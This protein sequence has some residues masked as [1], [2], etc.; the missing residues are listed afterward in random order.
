MPEKQPISLQ[1]SLTPWDLPHACLV[2]PH[3]L[4]FWSEHCTETLLFWDMEPG[5]RLA[6][7]HDHWQAC[8]EFLP[9]FQAAI[10]RDWPD[11]RQ[12]SQDYHGPQGQLELKTLSQTFF[13]SQGEIFT[14][15]IPIKDFR[16]GPLAAYLSAIMAAQ[17]NYVLHLDGD[18]LFAGS[19]SHWLATALTVLQNTPQFACVS[20]PGGPPAEPK[21][22]IWQPH[23]IF[24]SRCFLID[25]RSLY[26]ALSMRFRCPPE[27]TARG[28]VAP[29]AELFEVLVTAWQNDQN[30]FRLDYCPAGQTLW[31]LHPPVP[32]N[33]LYHSLLP[34]LLTHLQ[35]P[36]WPEAQ[37]GAYNLLPASLTWIAELE[38]ENRA[39]Q[40]QIRYT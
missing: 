2:L 7:A 23:S 27:P 11:M 9:E 25:R 34:T 1:I 40:A 36:S 20:P 32:P 24:S 30:R 28:W 37:L 31:S 29:Y 14:D 15:S 38:L 39:E 16:G 35:S 6:H 10:Q 17:S 18:M 33:A 3:Q 21:R 4:Q 19:A 22:L 8:L 5:P 13:Q 12:I 26:Q